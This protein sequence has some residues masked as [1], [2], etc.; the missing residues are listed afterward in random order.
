M[1]AEVAA[2]FCMGGCAGATLGC[3]SAGCLCCVARTGSP[4]INI[5]TSSICVTSMAAGAVGGSTAVSIVCMKDRID[6][7]QNKG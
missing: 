5:V 7:F 2:G 6:K 1:T 4:G 3:C